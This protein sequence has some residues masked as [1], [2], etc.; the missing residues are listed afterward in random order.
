MKTNRSNFVVYSAETKVKPISRPADILDLLQK[1]K[2]E[3]K[4]E[5]TSKILV[6]L[7]FLLLALFLSLIIVA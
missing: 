3:E 1:N 4:K 2:R 7:S 5:R 6:V